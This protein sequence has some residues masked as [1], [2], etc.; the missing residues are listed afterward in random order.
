MAITIFVVSQLL[1]II[2]L[3][4]MRNY[5]AEELPEWLVYTTVTVLF[6]SFAVFAFFTAS[7]NFRFR[8]SISMY[9]YLFLI[10]FN[11]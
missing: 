7:L 1:V 6:V 4:I 8:I 11:S 5:E 9:F 3:L 10:C 2:S